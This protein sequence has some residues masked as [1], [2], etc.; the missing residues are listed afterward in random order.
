MTPQELAQESCQYRGRGGISV[1]AR[2]FGFSP[3]F[4]DRETGRVFASC[5]RDG[6]PAGIHVMDGLPPEVVTERSLSG[7]VVSVKGTVVAGFIACG[8]FY[9]R[10]QASRVLAGQ[11][12]RSAR[13]PS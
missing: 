2:G 7:R 4:L 13:L 12:D 3:A 1:E 8:R 5:F 11:P 10:E 9:T 6:R